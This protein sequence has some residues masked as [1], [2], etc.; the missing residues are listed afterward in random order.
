MT[1]ASVRAT[2]PKGPLPE[3][4]VTLRS[5]RAPPVAR[6][7]GDGDAG[8]SYIAPVMVI[9]KSDPRDPFLLYTHRR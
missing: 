2:L 8:P 5:G 6:G 9:S 1:I 3:N 7:D 4:G